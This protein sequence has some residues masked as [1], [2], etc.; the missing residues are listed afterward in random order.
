MI[1]LHSPS[2]LNGV[3]FEERIEMQV[4]FGHQKMGGRESIA[5]TKICPETGQRREAVS[6][7]SSAGGE[8]NVGF[9]SHRGVC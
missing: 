1:L 6:E 3:G 4:R 5:G 8:E 9:R 7:D 2:I